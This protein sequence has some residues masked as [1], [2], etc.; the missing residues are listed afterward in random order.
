MTPF[1]L[2]HSIKDE[3][4]AYVVRLESSDSLIKKKKLLANKK[5]CL[6]FLTGLYAKLTF[7]ITFKVAHIN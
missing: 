6:M 2:E 3:Y 1:Y 5:R 4:V 7:K